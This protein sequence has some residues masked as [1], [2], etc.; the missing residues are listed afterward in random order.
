LE[1]LADTLY[2]QT[3]QLHTQAERSGIV[4]EILQ[5]RADRY[6][7][8][9]LLRN[10]L[11]VYGQME[12]GLEQHRQTPQIG[13]LAQPAV[14]RAKALQADLEALFGPSWSRVLPIL[15]AGERYRQ[16]VDAA[17]TGDGTAL[18]AH[19]YVRYLGDLNGGRILR[20]LLERS[21]GLDDDTLAFY[22][23]PD[24]ADLDQFKQAY[25]SAF[26]R[27]TLSDSTI[28]SVADEAAV[29]F[30]LNI[31]VSEAVRATVIEKDAV[32]NA[33]VRG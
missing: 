23:F 13:S 1:G 18:I 5:G 30:Q 7:Y 6:G 11:P 20:P 15:P 3:R 27:L 9:L 19:A 17:A 33:S 21:L 29:A 22:D 12:L 4:R 28:Q 14:Y 10:L 32:A 2:K 25:R 16:R 26:D 8:A 31:E 24:I